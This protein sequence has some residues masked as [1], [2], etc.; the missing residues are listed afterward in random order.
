MPRRYPLESLCMLRQRQLWERRS[1]LGCRAQRVRGAEREADAVRQAQG[2]IERSARHVARTE[3]DRL[4]SGA[5]RCA[6]LQ[7][8]AEFQRGVAARVAELGGQL[9][10][11]EDQ[12]R[13][14]QAGEAQ[15]R[16]TLGRAFGRARTVEAHRERWQQTLRRVQE[17]EEQAT[18]E[19]G[20]LAR[21]SKGSR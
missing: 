10:S 16:A 8:S 2:E 17:R 6:D 19:D 5:V 13:H 9:R 15:A 14:E 4:D 11:A 21:R 12:L 3:R 7:R 20:W 1:D 18:A